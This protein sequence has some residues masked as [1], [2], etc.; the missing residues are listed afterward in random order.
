M[1]TQITLKIQTP[2]VPNFVFIEMPSTGQ[3]QDGFKE[4]PKISV[5]DL[6]D[7]QLDALAHD[8]KIKLYANSKR[9]REGKV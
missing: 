1:K 2:T 4:Q 9:M 7:E 8:W 6:T 5:G 3:R